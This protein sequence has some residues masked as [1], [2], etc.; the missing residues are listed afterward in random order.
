[1]SLSLRRLA[2]RGLL[3][4]ALYLASPAFAEEAP[5]ATGPAVAETATAAEPAAAAADEPAAS[6]SGGFNAGAFDA[7]L[8]YRMGEVQLPNGKAVLRLGSQFRYL[9]PEDTKRLLEEAWGN[10]DGGDTQGM[11]VPA[12]LSPVGPG[13]W[14]VIV[15]YD[16]SG[17]VSDDDAKGIDYDEMLTEMK[18]S[19]KD[20]NAERAK[21]GFE[22]V[23]IVGWA[24]KPFYDAATNRLHWAKELHFGSEQ[25]NTLNYNIRVLGREGVLVLNAVAGMD[26]L[27]SIKPDLDAM[28]AVADFAPGH[29]YADYN[30]KTDRTAEYGIAALVAGGVAA[31]AGWLAPLLLFLKKGFVLVLLAFGWLGKKLLGVFRKEA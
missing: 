2:A 20:E 11:I 3:L 28:V 19:S 30:E 29:R 31:K 23:E 5:A 7:S 17:H 26:Q 1:M 8:H 27:A 14:G 16:D 10:P 6:G 15:Q 4:P 18:K 25:G 9:P 24:S 21:A 12:S 22:P 13:G